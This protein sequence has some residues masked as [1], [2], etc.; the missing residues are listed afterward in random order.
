MSS[1]RKDLSQNLK[2]SNDL[3]L[4]GYTGYQNASKTR[5]DI[6]SLVNEWVDA[7]PSRASR[8]LANVVDYDAPRVIEEKGC[9]VS[10]AVKNLFLVFGEARFGE[11]IIA[12][13]ALS[14]KA[15]CYEGGVQSFSQI[16]NFLQDNK[17]VKGLFGLRE[18]PDA[19]YFS[20]VE[21]LNGMKEKRNLSEGEV[22][23]HLETYLKSRKL[24]NPNR[25]DGSTKQ[26][27]FD[28]AWKKF[29]HQ[30]LWQKLNLCTFKK[31]EVI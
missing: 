30:K 17:P 7:D 13:D 11:D 31:V 12:S 21:F 22:I 10:L 1:V 19:R 4:W 9:G 29:T 20:A 26:A 24:F 16:V 27:L 2:S 25:Y 5:A 8:A 15:L 6:N 14:D 3:I 28:A 23:A 18:V